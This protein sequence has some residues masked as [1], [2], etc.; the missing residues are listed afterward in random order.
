MSP[1]MKGL[2]PERMGSQIPILP[3]GIA[4]SLNEHNQWHTRRPRIRERQDAFFLFAAPTP[5]V[6]PRPILNCTRPM[7]GAVLVCEPIATHDSPTSELSGTPCRV[8]HAPTR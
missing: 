1:R 2:A 8:I 7:N 3:I 5:R 4:T 6:C